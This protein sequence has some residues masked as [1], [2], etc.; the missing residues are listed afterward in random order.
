MKFLI[1]ANE[2]GSD[3][4]GQRSLAGCCMGSGLISKPERF[5]AN[6]RKEEQSC[7]IC[8]NSTIP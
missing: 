1:A 7:R 3:V 6:D 5:E 8:R 4:N 2:P